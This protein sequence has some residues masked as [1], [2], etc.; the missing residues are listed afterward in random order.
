VPDSP[1][2]FGTPDDVRAPLASR[3]TLVD[4]V[5]HH[6]MHAVGERW[7]A[8]KV[9]PSGD[10]GY[11]LDDD[12]TGLPDPRSRRQ[13]YGVHGRS[14]VVDPSGFAWSDQQWPGRSLSGSVIYELHVGTFTDE[15]TLDS[16]IAQLGDLVDLGIDFVELL[17]VNAFNGDHN[18]GYGGVLWF[19]M[20]ETYGG[21]DAYRRFVDAC[22]ARVLAVIHDVVYNHLCPSGNYL[23]RFGP[24]L[25]EADGTTWGA[26]LNLDGEDSRQVRDVIL[27]NALTWL[28]GYHVDGLRLDAVHTL[29]DTSHDARFRA[30]WNVLIIPRAHVRAPARSGND[31]DLAAGHLL[32]ESRSG[33]QPCHR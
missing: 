14:R 22:H 21:P 29:V 24:Y 32:S 20:Q 12:G 23:P 33:R 5:D 31:G 27:E 9:A 28:S 18:W 2:A 19:A 10:Y 4:G 7:W 25:N 3:V 11:L 8:A 26:S 16:A 13:P 6:T 15:G 30:R 17:P 1:R